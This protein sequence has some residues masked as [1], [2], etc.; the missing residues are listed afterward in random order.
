MPLY[1]FEHPETKEVTEVFFH[2]NDEDKI[3]IDDAGMQWNRVFTTS[4]LSTDTQ[5]DPYNSRDFINKT[6]K[7][8][9]MGD[10]WDRSAELH[11]KRVDKEGKDPI[12]Q[13]YFKQYS[14]ERN[15]AKHPRDTD[16]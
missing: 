12:Q 13:K 8:G 10:M 1:I 11:A 9:T 7:E 15:G 4:Q 2:M 14:A 5:I 6:S 16:G 3:Y